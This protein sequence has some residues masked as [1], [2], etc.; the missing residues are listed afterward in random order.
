[1]D[2]IK[3]RIYLFGAVILCIIFFSAIFVALFVVIH[4]TETVP[5]QNACKD[6]G[7]ETYERKGLFDYCENFNGDLYTVKL[8]CDR[9][10]IQ[11]CQAKKI[12]IYNYG[13][14]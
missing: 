7:F 12:N 14:E 1:M 6:I 5:K 2:N 11:K 10:F 9:G 8:E 13:E 4:L 3:E